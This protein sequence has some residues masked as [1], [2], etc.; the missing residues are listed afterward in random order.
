MVI[1]ITKMKEYI[2]KFSKDR[3][4]DKLHSPK[5]IT[6]DIVIE[7]SELMD[8]F[9]WLDRDQS[10]CVHKD[11]KVFEHVKEEMA[12]VLFALVRLSDLLNIDLNEAFWEK[13]KKNE[14]NRGRD[15]IP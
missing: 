6:M 14:L 4:W 3:N 15:A 8:I 5:N 12:D 9:T 7:A 1:E 10:Y 13:T 2:Q 11:E